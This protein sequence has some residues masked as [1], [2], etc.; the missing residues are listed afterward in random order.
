[1]Q[2]VWQRESAG[3]GGRVKRIVDPSGQHAA[4]ASISAR[5]IEGAEDSL[6]VENSWPDADRR[7]FAEKAFS[8][9]WAARQ[10]PRCAEGT[11][12]DPPRT[13]AR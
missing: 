10:S 9:P 11:G 12:R 4:V 13:T 3:A 5:Y 6:P 8:R 2:S 1:M 7:R